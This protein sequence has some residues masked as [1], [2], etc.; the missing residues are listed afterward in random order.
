[1]VKLFAFQGGGLENRKRL[2][3]YLASREAM[4][5]WEYF[6]SSEYLLKLHCIV[7]KLPLTT[8]PLC[9]SFVK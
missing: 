3:P 6:I 1:M 7:M 9:I 2:W 4:T 5:L 8:L